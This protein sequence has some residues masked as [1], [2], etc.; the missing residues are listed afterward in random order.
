VTT[1]VIVTATLSD[2][3]VDVGI[4]SQK[5]IGHVDNL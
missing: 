5:K 2:R 3:A 1:A 4:G